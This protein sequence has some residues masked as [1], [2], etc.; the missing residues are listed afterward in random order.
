MLLEP[1]CDYGLS[2]DKRQCSLLGN[3]VS[4]Q[5]TGTDILFMRVIA[6]RTLKEFW[7]RY[8]DAQSPLEA[9]HAEAKNADWKTSADIK[10]QYGTASILK[11][12]RVVFNIHG[13][14]YRLIVRIDYTYSIVFIRFIGTHKEYGQTDAEEV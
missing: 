10:Q 12:S 4:L 14:K 5:K 13:N 9:W 3:I 7:E 8:P 6:K 2:N 11:N 1:K